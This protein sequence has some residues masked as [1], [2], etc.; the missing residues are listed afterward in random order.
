MYYLTAAFAFP[1]NLVYLIKKQK[2]L[3]CK[4]FCLRFS[5]IDF[6]QQMWTF[7][8]RDIELVLSNCLCL[9]D[10]DQIQDFLSISITYVCNN[11]YM[12]STNKTKR[13]VYKTNAHPDKITSFKSKRTCVT[14]SLFFCEL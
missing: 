10:T 13:L 5:S 14:S 3:T 6:L 2:H 7:G 12:F 11:L 8:S 1:I 9:S 4:H